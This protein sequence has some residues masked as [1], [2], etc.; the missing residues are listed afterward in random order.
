MKRSEMIE[1]M[2]SAGEELVFQTDDNTEYFD[3]ILEKMENAGMLPPKV[4]VKLISTYEFNYWWEP[5]E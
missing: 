1:L 5:E 2:E 4:P 3:K